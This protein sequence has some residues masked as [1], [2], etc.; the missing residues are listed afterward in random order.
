MN[1]RTMIWILILVVL[2]GAGGFFIYQQ[3]VNAAHAAAV[4]LQTA[5]VTR[6]TLAA[7]VS[8]AGNIAAP[9]QTNLNFQL[10]GVPITKIDVQVGDQVK[11][12][13]VLAQ[14]DDSNLQFALRTAQ[15]NLAS[16][17]ANLAKLQQ[18]PLPADVA[19][20]QAA[21]ASAQSAYNVAVNKNAHASDSIASAKAAL[22]N[23]QAAVQQAQAAYDKIGGAS[24][25][26]IGMTSQSLAL[27]QATNNYQSALAAY[28][29]ALT[30]VND[31]AVKQAAQQ[32]ASAQ[33]SLVKLTQ[34]PTPQDIAQAQAQVNSAQVAVDQA[35]RNLDQAKIV[36]PFDGTVAAVNYV[37]GQLTPGGSG[38]STSSPVITLVNMNNLQTQVSLSEVDI[39]KVKPSD[40]VNLTFDAL[41]TQTFPG[42][43]VSIS[44]VGTITSG[45]VNYTVTVALTKPDPQIKPGM[46]TEASFVVAQDNNVLMV[47]NRAIHTQGTQHTMTI[48]FEG[49]QIPVVVQTGL[50]N[51]TQTE[52]TGASTPSGQPVTLQDGDT[53]VMNATTTTGGGNL[54]GV[55][56]GGGGGFFRGPG[57]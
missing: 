35:T 12:G 37:I 2:G 11:A 30:D 7:T 1:R 16:A 9:Q 8:G 24:N 29:L 51:D 56:G 43:I 34:P 5:T 17:Q 45:V 18:P 4:N 49:K 44:P 42:K 26:N 15:A 6:G 36:A 46:T 31:S 32:L 33:D 55:P 28:N 20:D 14:A 47:P 40:P 39:A 48:L 52:I 53:V 19:A 50:S 25:P 38:G 23:A 21:V 27:Q 57:G 54:R 3:Q 41:G 22:D 13:Q 10:A